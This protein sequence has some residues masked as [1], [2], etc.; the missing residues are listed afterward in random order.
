MK[1]ILSKREQ[2]ILYL[3]VGIIAFSVIFNFFLSPILTRDDNLNKE[4]NATRNKLKKYLRLLSQKEEIKRKYGAFLSSGPSSEKEDALSALSELESLA[5][6]SGIHIIDIRPD[7][8]SGSS[9]YKETVID[10]RAE[11]NMEG[12]LRFIYD[13]EHSLS[14]L[15]IR[16]LQLNS[17]PN[18]Q[19]LEGIFTISQYLNQD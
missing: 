3:T 2:L 10:L 5:N 7:S 1:R 19:T 14:S 9:G 12:F 8:A 13:I 17:K 4:I 16:K 15:S 18:L 6:K 11:G